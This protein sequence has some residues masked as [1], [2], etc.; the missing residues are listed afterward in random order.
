MVRPAANDAYF[1]AEARA[2]LDRMFADLRVAD[3]N[4]DQ[5]LLDAVKFTG[6]KIFTSEQITNGLRQIHAYKGQKGKAAILGR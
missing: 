3:H 5:V 2:S 4:Q 1:P 6:N